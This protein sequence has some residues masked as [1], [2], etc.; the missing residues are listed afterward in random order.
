MNEGWAIVIGFAVGAM[1][2]AIGSFAFID[3]V[4]RGPRIAG[5]ALIVAGLAFLVP[6]LVRL[7]LMTVLA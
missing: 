1:L 7:W 2:I 4:G 5:Y 6:A 3:D